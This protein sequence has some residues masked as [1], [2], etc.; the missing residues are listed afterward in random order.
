MTRTR[1]TTNWVPGM[2]AALLTIGTACPP[3][4]PAEQTQQEPGEK[5]LVLPRSTTGPQT[6]QS[7]LGPE[8]MMATTT[9][10]DD[11][12]EVV[13]LTP[14][15]DVQAAMQEL[16]E[17]GLY[18]VVERN[19]V[20]T[21][22]SVPNDTF[23]PFQWSF[24]DPQNFDI[25][26]PAAWDRRMDAGSIVVAVIDTG[27]DL[28][29]PDLAS[30]LWINPRE[31]A[32]NNRDD[33]ANG[34]VDDVHGADF[35]GYVNGTPRDGNPSDE[36]GH[37]THVAGIIG[38]AG[39]NRLGVSGVAQR[40]KLMPIRFAAS[41][42]GAQEAV[43]N[44]ADA[45]EAIRY[46]IANRADVIVTAWGF[47]EPSV[48]IQ[49]VIDEAE[50]AGILVVAAAGNRTG[51]GSFAFYPAMYPNPNV[52]GVAALDQSGQANYFTITGPNGS[53][54]EFATNYGPRIDLAAPGVGIFSTLP[55]GAYG[56]RSGTSAAAAHV[57]GAAALVKANFPS[58]S[59]ADVRSALVD[60][61]VPL[62]WLVPTSP[63]FVES[64]RRLDLSVAIL[65]WDHD[66]DGRPHTIDNCVDVYNPYQ[67]DID[68]DRL[69][70]H[71]DPDADGDGILNGPDNCDWIPNTNQSDL[72]ADG[73][74]DV[75]DSLPLG[76]APVAV[77][78]S[79]CMLRNT[80][81][82][83]R[84]RRND[85]DPDHDVS[86]LT[87]VAPYGVR[88]NGTLSPNPTN[89]A[90]PIFTPNRGFVGTASFY[91]Y[92]I[93]PLGNSSNEARV[94]IQVQTSCP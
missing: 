85:S 62:P 35:A 68:G 34:I 83:L 28:T 38:A 27:I 60:T 39:N 7:V 49:R 31:V 66:K 84:I 43:G 72:N 74:G 11:R 14:G 6:A 79:I 86:L 46:A 15:T 53:L 41:A 52:V 71:C 5:L 32:G 45:Q 61:G 55:G 64:G 67:E 42:N 40:V 51:R 19:Q 91:Y 92:L 1:P 69:G 36:N 37:G 89:P 81:R 80:S 8:V 94:N 65:G 54:G 22:Q 63:T 30:N 2:V 16:N 29:H 57:A 70:N 78:D 90:M 3:P 12:W 73:E 20:V 82:E 58:A 88:Q 47:Y 23:F 4:K 48:A 56:A 75:C 9:I 21:L 76:H 50:R 33:D 25:N 10:N 13:E 18:E 77:A 26:A 44:L 24:D 17:S 93:D 59:V 87:V